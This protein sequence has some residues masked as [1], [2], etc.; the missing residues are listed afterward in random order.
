MLVEFE[1]CFLDF[2]SQR[3]FFGMLVPGN[4]Q[5]Q[6]NAFVNREV[7]EMHYSS[8]LGIYTTC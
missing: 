7:E 5:Q 1:Q 3:L 6:Q 4:E 8:L 2:I